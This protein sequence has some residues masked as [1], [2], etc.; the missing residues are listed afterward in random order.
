MAMKSEW[1]EKDYYAD[2]GV[3][4]TASESEIKKAYRK[5]A[6]ENHPDSHPGDAAAE[7][8]FKKIAEA[9]DVLGNEQE[10]QEYD[11]FKTMMR[12]GGFGQNVGS[13]FAGGFRNSTEFDFGD[14]FG[15]AGQGQSGGFEDIL[16]GLFNSN[17]GTRRAK[18]PQRGAD[19]E[20]SITLEFR[21]AAQGAAI[22]IQLTGEAPCTVCHG[23]G[24]K[25]GKV[26]SCPDC[27]GSGFS[28]EE[29]GTFGFSRPCPTCHST[30][31]IVEDPCNTCSGSGTVRRT[32]SIT[33]K[34]P[35]GVVDSQRV[36][37]AGQGEAGPN[38]APSGDLYVT[39][40][41]KSD[42]VFA[43][44]GDN[45]EITVPVSFAELALGGTIIVP[46]LDQPVRVKIPTG[47]PDGRV[48][49]VKGRGVPKRSDKAGDLLV[50]LQVEI[51]ANLDPAALSALRAYAQAERD[52]GFDPRENWVGNKH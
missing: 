44:S 4:P 9:Y 3:A 29:R 51:P 36:R 34:I 7:E 42:E 17:G 5:L 26:R 24:S 49:R 16:G 2:L 40:H 48:L 19:V 1:A 18:K 43:R 47:T 21:E 20:T 45:L 8:K 27:Q 28:T 6:R 38:G 37:L 12:N 10:R 11:Q 50:K 32:R 52:A 39:V 14:I 41:V 25:T 23:S 22:P 15:G 33:V 35:P 30:G 46:T 13:G 31:K